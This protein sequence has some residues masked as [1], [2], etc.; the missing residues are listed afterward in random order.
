VG[1]NDTNHATFNP[2]YPIKAKA[3]RDAWQKNRTPSTPED[4]RVDIT[5]TTNE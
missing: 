5:I 4:P 2:H 1:N 3:I